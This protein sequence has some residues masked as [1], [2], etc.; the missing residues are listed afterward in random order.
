MQEVFFLFLFIVLFYGYNID[1]KYDQTQIQQNSMK[2]SD[3][4][5]K[6]THSMPPFIN[7]VFNLAAKIMY[8]YY[9]RIW[10]TTVLARSIKI[11]QKK[12]D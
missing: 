1:E 9:M 5:V 7:L 3:Y 8:I 2:P 11:L 6:F 12:N 4:Q 10:T